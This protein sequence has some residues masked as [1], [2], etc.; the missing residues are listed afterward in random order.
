ML[1]HDEFHIPITMYS[2]PLHAS[3]DWTYFMSQMQ[4]GDY[5]F[6]KFSHSTMSATTL[7]SSIRLNDYNVY[8]ICH[9]GD[10]LDYIVALY[11]PTN[12]IEVLT[13]KVSGST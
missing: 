3:K 2:D 11:T 8:D 4:P 6:K 7:M 10:V 5:A 9:N 12:E 1:L 13:L